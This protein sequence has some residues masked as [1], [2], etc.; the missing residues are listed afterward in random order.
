[1]APVFPV[2]IAETPKR[3]GSQQAANVIGLEVAAAVV[4]G[5]GLP[6]AFGL[7]AART[8]LEVIPPLLLSLA[9]L[10]LVLH[11]TLARVAQRRNP[12]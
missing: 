1:L 5:A 4:G 3:I 12:K 9:A 10:Q 2:L 11:E 8:T 7:V 6:A